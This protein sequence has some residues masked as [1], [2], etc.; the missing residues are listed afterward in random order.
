MQQ[1]EAFEAERPRLVGLATRVLGD[2]SGAEDIVQQAWLRLHGTDASIDSVPAWLTTVTVR[3]CLDR[4]RLRTPIPTAEIE[5]PGTA[6]D[7][8]EEV[9]LADAV[10]V[11]LQVVLDRLTPKE[12]IAFVLHDSFGFEF[13]TIAAILD[14]TPAAARKLASRARAKV[15]QPRPEDQLADWEVVDA[16]LAAAR[17]GDFAR[18]LQ[19]LA[20]DVVVVGDEAAIL[21]GTPE[22][23]DGRQEVA[24]FFNGGAAAALSVFIGERPGAAWFH[25]GQA[26]V[27]F[28][29]TIVDGLVERIDF[30]ADPEL[31]TQLR[32]RRQSHE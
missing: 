18:L 23:I 1:T 19:L 17:G 26:R 12:R 28:D 24:A 5:L 21:S 29:F 11:A 31:L 9:E 25:R 13:P 20:P 14:T 7:P 16:F 4:L 3:L 30:R 15:G 22:R 6:P 27:A 8:A 10:G 2:P 32:R